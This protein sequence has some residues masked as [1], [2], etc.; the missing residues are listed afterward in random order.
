MFWKRKVICC[1]YFVSGVWILFSRNWQGRY[2]DFASSWWCLSSVYR[3]QPQK[4]NNFWA[5]VCW[6]AIPIEMRGKTR[7]VLTCDVG[8]SHPLPLLS[9]S[10]TQDK[11]GGDFSLAE[12]TF[13]V[14]S[15]AS[16]LPH[17]F[18]FQSQIGSDLIHIVMSLRRFVGHF[19]L[20]EF[21]LS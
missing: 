8:A 14:Y 5:I 1:F 9:W 16:R 11:F 21:W 2:N 4:I 12:L 19:L 3:I 17:M 13:S 18:P 7:S 10:W 6:K 20:G 15:V